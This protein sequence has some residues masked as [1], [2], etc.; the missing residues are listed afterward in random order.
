M[1]R[2]H[3]YF[4]APVVSHF[5]EVVLARKRAIKYSE[6]TR[7]EAPEGFALVSPVMI[8]TQC[9]GA[10]MRS[11]VIFVVFLMNASAWITHF[12][13]RST[14]CTRVDLSLLRQFRVGKSWKRLFTRTLRVVCRD[15]SYAVERD[16]CWLAVPDYSFRATGC[17]PSIAAG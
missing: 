5:K 6:Q 11:T 7:S 1:L 4:G 2:A 17:K 3:V 8:Y 16:H 15:L 9:L 10:P 13:S 12:E 14:C